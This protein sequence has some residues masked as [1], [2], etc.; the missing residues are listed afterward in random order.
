MLI[1]LYVFESLTK[2]VQC[3][4]LCVGI[5]V[6]THMRMRGYIRFT[7]WSSV[8][9]CVC[10]GISVHT[11]I[12]VRGARTG[13]DALVVRGLKSRSHQHVDSPHPRTTRCIVVLS[14]FHVLSG[15]VHLARI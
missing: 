15:F 12:A 9:I 13:L 5:S 6:H 3:V 4:G 7:T 2:T 11:H 8:C 14:D 1:E 10:V